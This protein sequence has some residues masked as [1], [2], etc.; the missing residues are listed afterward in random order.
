MS[1]KN[2]RN[3]IVYERS[4]G[5]WVA[6]IPAIRGAYSQGR[7]KSEAHANLVDALVGIVE[8]YRQMAGPLA[9]TLTHALPNDEPIGPKTREE[10]RCARAS[11]KAGLVFTTGEVRKRLKIGKTRTD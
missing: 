3:K 10:I 1:P 11:A 7:T 2:S 5:W 9:R 4:S 8:T 6:S